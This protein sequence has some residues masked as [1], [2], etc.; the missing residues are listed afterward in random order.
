MELGH[1]VTSMLTAPL[2]HAVPSQ[3]S[4]RA[5]DGPRHPRRVRAPGR[6]WKRGAGEFTGELGLKSLQIPA[7]R[8]SRKPLRVVRPVEGSNPSPSASSRDRLLK[9]FLGYRLIQEPSGRASG[10]QQRRDGLLTDW[11]TTAAGTLTDVAEADERRATVAGPRSAGRRVSFPMRLA[12]HWAAIER[13]RGQRRARKP[14][15][16]RDRRA[17]RS[18]ERNERRAT[19]RVTASAAAHASGHASSRRP[20]PLQPRDQRRRCRH[21]FCRERAFRVRWQSCR[22]ASRWRRARP[23]G[24]RSSVPSDRLQRHR[25]QAPPRPRLVSPPYANARSA[26]TTPAGDVGVPLVERNRGHREAVHSRRG[27]Q[28]VNAGSFA[29]SGHL[30]STV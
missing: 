17:L 5:G 19:R 4:R 18:R 20:L 11:A 3:R 1:D 2:P 16:A 26:Y 23:R 8:R 15:V 28:D 29:R 24:S 9:R 21:A 14:P 22:A 12:H 7:C 30:V 13:R 25:P 10:R 27:T 6:A